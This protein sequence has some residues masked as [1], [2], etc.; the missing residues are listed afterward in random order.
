MTIDFNLCD[1]HRRNMI[2][3]FFI[4][5]RNMTDIG[6]PKDLPFALAPHFY[7]LLLIVEE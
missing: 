6:C 4:I 2:R 1:D 7:I 5:I 3:K